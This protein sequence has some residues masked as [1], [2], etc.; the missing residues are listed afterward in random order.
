MLISV[1][2]ETMDPTAD[3]LYL[4]HTVSYNNSNWSALYHNIKKYRRWCG[5]VAKVL[6]KVGS[7]VRSWVIMCKA[8]VQKVSL[9]ESEIWVVTVAMLTVI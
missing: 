9:Y 8:M 2:A 1:N 7:S 6:T 5:M 3:F 4:D